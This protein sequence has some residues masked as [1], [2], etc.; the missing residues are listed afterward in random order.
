M[1]LQIIYHK[2]QLQGEKAAKSQLKWN[3]R[4]VRLEKGTKQK[5]TKTRG[6]EKLTGTSF[7]NYKQ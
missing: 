5:Y 1:C 7:S 6:A 3:F 4:W 2:S